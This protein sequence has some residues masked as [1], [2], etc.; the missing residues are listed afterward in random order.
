MLSRNSNI[1]G[2]NQEGTATLMQVAQLY[3][4]AREG[5][6][7]FEDAVS[8][9]AEI[10]GRPVEK[11]NNLILALLRIRHHNQKERHDAELLRDLAITYFSELIKSGNEEVRN[12]AIK[13][14]A[15]LD[16]RRLFSSSKIFSVLNSLL[17]SDIEQQNKYAMLIYGKLLRSSSGEVRSFAKINLMVRNSL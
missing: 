5:G 15:E 7:G 6:E 13:C 2:K 3:N 17:D 16:S 14:A 1:D 4:V 10:I 9:L 8:A 12:A 11:R